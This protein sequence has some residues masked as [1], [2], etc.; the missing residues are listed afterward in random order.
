MVYRR[1][2][3]TPSAQARMAAVQLTASKHRWAVAA[4]SRDRA[5][6]QTST[7]AKGS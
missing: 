3:S 6:P 4:A 1:M 2:P 5:M 7:K